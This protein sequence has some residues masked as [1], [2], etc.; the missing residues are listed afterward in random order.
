[1][2]KKLISLILALA[3]VCS[4]LTLPA[5][6]AG[7]GNFRDITDRDV[8]V[9]VE[10]L[11]LLGVL[12]GY[13]DGTFR[14]ENTLTRAQFCKMTVFAMNGGAESARYKA[15]T[16]YPDVKSGH[17]AAAYINMASKGRK[18]LMGYPDG[19]FY[20]DKT[21]TFAQAVTILMRLLGYQD[22]DVGP[23]WPTGHLEAART[24]GLLRGLENV[25]TYAPLKRGQAAILFANLLGVDTKN[26]GAY[27]ASLGSL[28][29]NVIL[30][31]CNAVAADGT[32]G[33]MQLSDGSV[34][35]VAGRSGSGL[36]NGQKGTL[37]LDSAR[38]ALTFVPAVKGESRLVK[39]EAADPGGLSAVGGA[40]Y[41]M[42]ADI[43][44]WVDGKQQVWGE[45]YAWLTPNGTATLHIGP[46]GKVEY[47]FLGGTEPAAAAVLIGADGSVSDLA[48]LTG[49][50]VG[51]KIVKDGAPASV[52]DLRRNDVATYDAAAN[53]VEVCTTRL[54]GIYENC[55]PNPQS[56]ARITLLGQDFDVL[57]SAV[58]ML[59]AMRL[60][61]QITLLLTA[62]NQVAG[63]VSGTVG[64]AVGIVTALSENAATVRLLCGLTV[65]GDP[66]LVSYQVEV[67]AGQL[68]E[69]NCY[70]KGKLTLRR[71]MTGTSDSFDVSARKVGDTPLAENAVIYERVGQSAVMAIT[72]G[73][74]RTSAVPASKIVHAGR[75]WAGDIDILVLDDVTGSHFVYGR[76]GYTA[77]VGGDIWSEA[78]V[79][80]TAA[81]GKVHG[82]YKCGFACEDGD[83]MGIV[84]A[85][86]G[87]RV[88]GVSRLT[89]LADVSNAAWSGASAV[90]V[91]GVTYTV[92]EDVI[93]YNR[94]AGTYLSLTA[95]RAFAAK[96][97]LYADADRII[98][99]VEVG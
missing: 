98:R 2:K 55:W 60:G 18:I 80:L 36:L 34:Y 13:G 30:V 20:P 93:C 71:L 5:A 11:R 17:W 65:T 43:P 73:E 14:P 6:A 47:V 58:D 59:A 89:R 68:V 46:G 40:R 44:V 38:R 76:I 24:I 74:I 96:A 35:P 19:K 91:A 8:A 77:P 64:N 28:V 54:S 63:A 32:T 86:T 37:V 81:D 99:A 33:A 25:E 53:T 21:V 49:G 57:P 79:T 78:S 4:L 9:A 39:I 29:E 90:T 75:N 97:D 84:V 12:D 3:V 7:E 41:A 72:T 67:L 50:A 69:V 70:A 66:E 26:G 23:V 94:A 22:T 15:Y 27:A 95:A 10:S 31:S 52:S 87:D 92:A 45:A 51:W 88:S 1:M 56:P 82:P 16:I 85:G 83:Y 42:T 61:S 48:A 62:D